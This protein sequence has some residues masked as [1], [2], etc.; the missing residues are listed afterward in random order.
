M[1]Q[2]SGVLEITH[3]LVAPHTLKR[4]FGHIQVATTVVPYSHIPGGPHIDNHAPGDC[5]QE[6]CAIRSG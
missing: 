4:R 2:G 6:S 1:L 3:E 5:E